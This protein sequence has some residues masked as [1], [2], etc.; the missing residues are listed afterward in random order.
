M[1]DC[2]DEQDGR[3]CPSCDKPQCS[4]AE[5]CDLALARIIEHKEGWDAFVAANPEV[6]HHGTDRIHESD[7]WME[8]VVWLLAKDHVSQGDILGMLVE[9]SHKINLA[10]MPVRMGKNGET[11]H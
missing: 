2:R 4:L 3:V 11:K 1:T 10:M 5:W 9:I 8:F 7:R 6:S